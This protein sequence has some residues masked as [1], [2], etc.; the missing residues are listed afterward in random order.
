MGGI[1]EDVVFSTVRERREDAAKHFAAS[2]FATMSVKALVQLLEIPRWLSS[3]K[4]QL[5]WTS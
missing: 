1:S 5:K 4:Y 2:G 3:K